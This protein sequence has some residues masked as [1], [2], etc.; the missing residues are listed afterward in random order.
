MKQKIMFGEWLPDQPGVTGAVTDAKNCYP[1]T[2]GYAP[3]K[4]EADYSSD[5]DTDL[6]T[7]FAGKYD[8][9]TSLFAASASKVY[10]FNS[11]DFSLTALNTTGY[12][13]V[14]SWDITQFGSKMILAN[15]VDKLQSVTLNVTPQPINDLSASAPVARYVTVVRDFVVAANDGTNTSKVYWSDIN[16]ETDWTPAST[17]QSDFQVLP[18][19]GDITGLAGGEYGLIFLE[20]AI[21]RMTYTGSPFFFQFDAISRT[22]GCISN[23]S[24]VQY[25][26]LTY[27]LA[28]DGFY[29]C[30]GQSTKSIG[31]EKVNRWFFSNAIPGQISTGMSTTV[32]PVNKLIYWKFNNIF[33]SNSIL[34]YSIELNKWSYAETTATA[35]AFGLTPSATLEQ[36]D[37]YFFNS[38]KAKTGTYT[39]SGTTVTVSVTNHGVE[40][41][42]RIK[43]DA[44]SGAGVDGTFQITKVNANT[45]TF[46]AAASATISTS[47]CTIT[48][49]DIDVNE[50]SG[51]EI[52]LDS[53][54]WAGG[55]LLLLG[56]SNRKIIAFSGQPK[57]ANIATGD[58]DIGRSTITLA[59]PILDAG[60]GGTSRA[61]VA[62][63]SRDNL[64]EQVTYGSDVLADAENR[65]SLRS[66][67]DYHRLKMTPQGNTWKT[68]VGIEVDIVKQGD[69]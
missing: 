35:V 24:I 27:F 65:V 32:D 39:Q 14:E 62:V 9:V 22:L 2:N 34:I 11:S 30:D 63:A 18:D 1:V 33:G 8:S 26:N 10:K 66:N 48:F 58:I 50:N 69:R 25:G 52:P 53:R 23:G 55:I 12:S 64:Y 6:I 44:T 31:A 7:V 67:G 19:G 16:D 4:S 59:R 61:F 41:N 57:T 42:A 45:F 36:I 46:T 5:A 15:G 28:D 29:L 43:F 49:P 40:T 47:D 21:Y 60:S 20:R 68:A 3:L 56:A 17:S 38:S 54:V 37:I 51:N 13:G